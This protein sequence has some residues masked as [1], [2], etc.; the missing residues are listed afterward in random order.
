MTEHIV[1]LEYP[2]SDWGTDLVKFHFDHDV[3]AY[4]LENELDFAR[5]DISAEDF[6][7]LQ[8]YAD[9]V[10]TAAAEALRGTWSFVAQTCVIQIRY[11]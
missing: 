5:N 1:L 9:A 3:S 7:T 4:D 10:C 6:D 11:S 2:E 8:D